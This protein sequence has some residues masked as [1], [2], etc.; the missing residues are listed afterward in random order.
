M[1][2]YEYSYLEVVLVFLFTII[3]FPMARK[4]LCVFLPSVAPSA[5]HV[6]SD[7]CGCTRLLPREQLEVLEAK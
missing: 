7:C 2:Y 6:Q 5:T 3:R 1:I 4:V